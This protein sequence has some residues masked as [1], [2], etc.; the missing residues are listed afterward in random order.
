MV[1]LLTRMSDDSKYA[2]MFAVVTVAWS[3]LLSNLIFLVFFF[4]IHSLCAAD[5]TIVYI[6]F[7]Y[8]MCLHKPRFRVKSQY[9]L[10]I[11]LQTVIESLSTFRTTAEGKSESSDPVKH[12]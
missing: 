7:R 11:Q 3:A 10:L 1:L 6:A 4:Y 2:F 5:K 9:I 12:I 8:M